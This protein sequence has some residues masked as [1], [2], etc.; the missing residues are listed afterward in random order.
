MNK[1]KIKQDYTKYDEDD[2][3]DEEEAEECARDVVSCWRFFSAG[4]IYSLSN[5]RENILDIYVKNAMVICHTFSANWR[6]I[7]HWLR[8]TIPITLILCW[9]LENWSQKWLKIISQ[10]LQSKKQNCV[11]STDKIVGTGITKR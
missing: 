2:T 1:R 11:R 5:F 10:K 4:Q 9:S 7:R 8:Q 6:P 3:D